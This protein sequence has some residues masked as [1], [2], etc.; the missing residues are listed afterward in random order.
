MKGKIIVIEGTDGSGKKTQTELLF[1]HFKEQGKNVIMQSFPNYDSPSSSPV[2]MYL[3]G[4]LG[5]NA[6]S[7]DAYSA[8]VLFAVDR[9]CT[10]QS[11]KAKY[12]NGAI[13]LFDRYVES[14]MLHQA[15]KIEDASE[16]EK[17]LNWLDNL[18]F[19]TLH[20][21]RPDKIIFLDMPPKISKKLA[22][23]RTDLKAGTKKDI[24]EQDENH[25]IHAYESGKY[26]SKKYNWETI[27]C[28][29]AEG[30]LKSIAEIH[31]EVLNVI[32]M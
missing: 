4:E 8:S 22:N 1:K 11:L 32:E 7:L 12:E 28:L 31:N 10:W 23:E 5:E 21:P 27:N 3:N 26:V 13:I 24:H 9:V 19:D 18:E 20:L 17:F 30:N 15:G 16:R 2:K 14:N 25:L 6:N 29:D